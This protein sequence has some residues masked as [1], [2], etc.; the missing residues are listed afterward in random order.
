[1][2]SHPTLPDI[3]LGD[4]PSRRT[5]YFG[6]LEIEYD[7]RVLT[8]RQWTT[9]QA[10]WMAD[11]LDRLPEGPVLELCSGTGHI[12]LLTG[13]YTA[14]D[15]VLVDA[16]EA[17]CELA[18]RN[19]AANP[20]SGSV[21]VRRGRVDEAIAPEERFVG[22]LADPPWVPS[23]Q[24]STFPDDPLTAIDGGE[25]GLALARVCLRVIDRHL[26]PQGAAILQLGTTA[27]AD[28]LMDALA[29]DERAGP[30]LERV[31]TRAFGNRGVLLHLARRP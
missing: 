11:V 21:E 29:S 7:E 5:V 30:S 1:M 19:L 12:G 26:A 20:V 28:Q 25:D 15:L 3:T 17:A 14:R 6:G 31:E 23:A 10:R 13:A 2:V 16:S 9:A 18:E 27:Q 22:I 4:E 24:T 8:P